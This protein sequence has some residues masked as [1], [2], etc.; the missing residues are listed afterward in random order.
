MGSP[1]PTYQWRKNGTNITGTTVATYTAPATVIGDNGAL[2]SVVVTNTAGTV[3]SA[4]ATLMVTKKGMAMQLKMETG[5]VACAKFIG[6]GAEWDLANY[7]VAGV[8]DADFAVIHRRVEWMRLP[9]AR[10][11]MPVKWCRQ[12]DGSFD[13][14]TAP[15]RDLYRNRDVCEAL[16][17]TVFLTDWGCM[18]EWLRAPGIGDVA[19]PL[20]AESIGA[21]L[22]HLINTKKYQC[23]RYVIMV[24]EPNWEVKEF[25]LWRRGLEQVAAELNRRG[26]DRQIQLAAPTRQH[27]A[28]VFSL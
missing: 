2:F 11:M 1:M 28:L 14:D 10:I 12:A 25:A 20:Y 6:F 26:L 27:D 24:N 19:D 17:T 16:G 9:A 21:Y 7:R 8:T 23:I 4:N 22:D 5:N 18:P 13:F 3:T 15:M